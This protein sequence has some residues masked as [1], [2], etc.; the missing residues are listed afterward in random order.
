MTWSWPIRTRTR[1]RKPLRRIV[2]FSKNLDG[3]IIDPA[4]GNVERGHEH[5]R[6]LLAGDLPVV[7]V[8]KSFRKLAADVVVS[9]NMEGAYQLTRE[10]IDR[11]HRR[12]AFITEPLMQQRAGSMQGFSQCGR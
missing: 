7:L 1:K 9:N 5:T 10:I 8:D 6:R 4:L 11:G 3:L 12:L 2:Y